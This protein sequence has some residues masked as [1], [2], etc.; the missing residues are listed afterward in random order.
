[1]LDWDLNKHKDTYVCIHMYA[2][3]HVYCIVSLARWICVF[4][5][6]HIFACK[7]KI[8]NLVFMLDGAIKMCWYLILVGNW[9]MDCIFNLMGFRLFMITWLRKLMLRSCDHIMHTFRF[10]E[11]NM[12][13]SKL[14]CFWYVTLYP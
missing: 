8:L 11:E 2:W 3:M 13:I 6:N 5:M 7:R 9:M 10:G 1:M 14:L 12:W 4:E